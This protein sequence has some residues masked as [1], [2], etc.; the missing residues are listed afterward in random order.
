MTITV[1]FIPKGLR[2]AWQQPRKW[3]TRTTVF[4]IHLW[5]GIYIGMFTVIAGVT[6]SALVYRQ[7]LDRCLAPHLLVTQL[8]S[9]S[10]SVDRLL[11]QVSHSNLGWKTKEIDLKPVGTSWMVRLVR[12]HKTDRL[13]YFDP[14]TGTFLGERGPRQGLIDWIADIHTNLLAGSIGRLVNGL[15]GAALF[16]LCFSGIILW[17]PGQHRVKK[18]L[19]IHWRARWRRLNW[20][21][22]TFGGF[23]VSIPLAV[24]SFTGLVL[25]FPIIAFVF[26]LLLGSSPQSII[27]FLSPPRSVVPLVHAAAALDPMIAQ[28]RQQFPRAREFQLLFLPELTGPVTLAS[29]D[30]TFDT[31]GT[32][33]VMNFDQYN[34]KLLN[35]ADMG[36]APFAIRALFYIRPLHYGS[37]AGTPSKVL[38]IVVG[39]TPGALFITGF[40]M[41]WRRA[42]I[43]KARATFLEVR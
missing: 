23:W 3:L 35:S 34:G 39:L 6:G 24:Q 9:P 30:S 41:W 13:L 33:G 29:I 31:N 1:A 18:S 19:N 16:I 36:R 7:G 32:Y 20:D 11:Q 4:K 43:N 42:S 26:A 37:F 8:E 14:T 38:W 21:L 28:G 12:E 27:A 5:C 22:H 15:F 10:V 17:W 2:T 25:C 40:L